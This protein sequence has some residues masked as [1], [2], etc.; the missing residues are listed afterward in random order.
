V[1]PVQN[2]DKQ[3]QQQRQQ[4]T[5]SDVHT[6]PAHIVTLLAGARHARRS[7]AQRA[8]VPAQRIYLGLQLR[9]QA[10]LRPVP[11]QPVVPRS[12]YVRQR[13]LA[14]ECEPMKYMM[15]VVVDPAAAAEAEPSEDD[16]TIEQ[17][18]AEVEGRGKRVTGDALRPTSEAV[19]VRVSHGQVLVTDGPFSET[20]EWIAGFDILECENL[21]EAIAIAARHPQANGGK[22][23]LR[24]FWTAED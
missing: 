20:K 2:H 6:G 3:R 18:L 4:N 24:P 13:R 10:T 7:A 22:L 23:E 11:V 14:K 12:S 21:D 8:V 17:W 19:T 9:Q 5:A 1:E 15:F 16:L